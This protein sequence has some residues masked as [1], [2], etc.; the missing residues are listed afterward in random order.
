MSR[1]CCP[2]WI[3]QPLIVDAWLSALG[4]AFAERDGDPGQTAV[5]P[6]DYL[7][8]RVTKGAAASGPLLS[9]TL[10]G[11]TRALARRWGDDPAAWRWRDAHRAVF[12]NR[13]WDALPLIG[14]WRR[15]SIPVGGDSSTVDAQA[16]VAAADGAMLQ[17]VPGASFRAVDDLADPA[18]SRFV[19]STG[20][21]GNPFSRHLL[22][23]APLWAS[24][25]SV[26][27][28]PVAD[29]NMGELTLKP[30]R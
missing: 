15:A 11:A 29:R 18:R 6:L 8:T 25:A 26:P 21:S 23:F 16:A 7:A 1:P 19:I 30:D 2:S 20:E 4:R 9:R 24:G 3:G 27:L 14:W 28:G 13:L 5:A 10:A 17:S 12:H 22:D